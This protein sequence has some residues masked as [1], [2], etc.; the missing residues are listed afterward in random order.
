[1]TYDPFARGPYP[2]GVESDEWT[3]A[4]R[5]RSLPIEIW[6]PAADSY[7]GQDLSPETWDVFSPGWTADAVESDDL[8]HQEAVRDARWREISPAETPLVLLVH[9]WAGFRREATFLATQL[10]SHGYVVVSPDVLGSTY[11]DVDR[12]LVEQ[13]GVGDSSALVSH[14]KEIA[15]LRRGDIPFLIDSATARLPVRTSGVGVTGASFGGWSSLIAPEVDGRVTA[16]V[17]MCPA[18]DDAPIREP[19]STLFGADEQPEWLSPAATLILAGDRDSL[20]PL[21]GQLRVLRKLPAA[22]KQMVVLTRADHNHFVD[23]IDTGQ[24]WLKEFADR[25]A[26]VFPNGPGRW[27]LV[28]STISPIELLTPGSEA[29]LA[30]RGLTTAHFDRHLRGLTEADLVLDDPESALAALGVEA[31]RVLGP[32]VVQAAGSR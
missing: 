30:W 9:G 17:P 32:D 4:T 31:S 23:D 3:D 21:Y 24:A 13:D 16:V 28:A 26:A 11:A 22:S 10:A 8:A 14:T 20:L 6:Y 2:V 5:D 27:D 1:M 18:N 25:V 7:R 15:R 19:G 12:L 29:K